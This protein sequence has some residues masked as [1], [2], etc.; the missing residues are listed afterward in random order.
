MARRYRI[1]ATGKV[2]LATP[3]QHVVVTDGGHGDQ[4]TYA[5]VEAL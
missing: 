3:F 4:Y 1:K 5:E 2:I